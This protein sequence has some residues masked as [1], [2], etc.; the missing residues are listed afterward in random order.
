MSGLV[1]VNVVVYLT[2]PNRA[3]TAV[4]SR[5]TMLACMHV[6]DC[7]GVGVVVVEVVVG[8][9]LLRSLVRGSQHVCVCVCVCVCVRVCV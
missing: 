5:A 3:S 4:E 7:W 9:G 2:G 8:V 1:A 6:A